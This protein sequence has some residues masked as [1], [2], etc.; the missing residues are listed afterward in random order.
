M[1]YRFASISLFVLLAGC[2]GTQQASVQPVANPVVAAE[3]TPAR[4]A[5]TGATPVLVV[6]DATPASTVS[7]PGQPQS[8]DPLQCMMAWT[9]NVQNV[10]MSGTPAMQAGDVHASKH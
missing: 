1:P 9:K 10:L 4:P 3:T 8:L 2:A 7:S 6:G 5:E